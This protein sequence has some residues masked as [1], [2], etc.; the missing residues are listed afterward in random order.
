[1]LCRQIPTQKVAP[2]GSKTKHHHAKKQRVILPTV[3]QAQDSA[4]S[5]APAF[6]AA[7]ALA[8]LAAF[9]PPNAHAV[10]GGGGTGT[11]V[12]LAFQDLSSKDF[13][14]QKLYKADLRGTNFSKANMEGASLFGA[15]C[16]DAKFV[17]ARLNNADLESVDFENADLS[18]AVL[19]GAQVTNAKFKNVNIV[20]SDWTD[21]VLRRDVQ[22]Q[23]C[24]IAS[25]TNPVT[26]MDTRES[27][28]CS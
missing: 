10:S 15:F 2:F 23:L 9:T 28:V 19:E 16:K 27:L 8:A 14:G 3:A 6:L 12:P 5:R 1:M 21:V 17:G 25:G 11:G 4:E 13:R 24:K 7:A 26:G 20:G 18:E 22:Q